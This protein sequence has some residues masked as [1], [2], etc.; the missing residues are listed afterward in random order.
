MLREKT[1]DARTVDR[2]ISNN[3]LNTT[4]YKLYTTISTYVVVAYQPSLSKVSWKS[5]LSDP[6][7]SSLSLS[8]F[9]KFGT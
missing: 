1:N 7:V 5:N 3:R 4:Q 8:T 9:E 2:K 6:S